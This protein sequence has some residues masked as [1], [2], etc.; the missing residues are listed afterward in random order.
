[1][2]QLIPYEAAR[3]KAEIDDP[4]VFARV[5]ILADRIEAEL[6]APQSQAVFP[7]YS[8]L[9]ARHGWWAARPTSWKLEFFP[10]ETR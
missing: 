7:E 6:H 3:L 4:Q 5:D 9:A 8:R 2:P 1:M 10:H